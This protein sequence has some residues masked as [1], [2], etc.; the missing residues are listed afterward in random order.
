MKQIADISHHDHPINWDL[1]RPALD[2]VIFRASI[3]KDGKDKKYLQYTAEC[4]L[5]YG[6]YHYVKAGTAEEAREEAK[7]F[8][9]FA[10]SAIQR[11]LFYIADIEYEAQTEKTTEPVCIAF[12][13][14]LRKLG[15]KKIGLYINRKYKYAGKAIDMC[16]IVW[17]P[18]WGPND[19]NI[20]GD[21]A[22]PKHYNDIW[23]YTSEGHLPG[24]DEGVDLDLLNGDKPLEY[25][26]E[27][28]VPPKREEEPAYEKFTNMHFVDFCRKFVG[29]PYWYGTTI[30]ACTE[31]KLKSKAKQYPEHY[32]EDRMSRYKKDIAQ[33]KICADCVG[34]IK[35]YI[36][37]NAGEGVIESIGKEKPL[38]K[39]EYESRGMPDKSANSLFSYAKKQGLDWGDIDT[40]PE[41]PGLGLHK[42][43]HVGVYIGNGEAIEERGFNYG[44][45]KTKVKDRK[46]LHWF[47]IP[48]IIYQENQAVPST[49]VLGETIL[50]KGSTGAA[51][52]ELQTQ[53]NIL[54]KSD[55]EVDGIFG[56][57]TR[58][59]VM[60]FQAEFELPIT[61]VYDEPSHKA[62][63]AALSDS[64]QE[65]DRQQEE[66]I[67][68][69]QSEEVIIP[70]GPV[71]EELIIPERPA[72][73]TY[74]T[75]NSVNVRVGDGTSYEKIT[76]LGKNVS[77]NIVMGKDDKPVVS[78]NGWYA[79]YIMGR[80]GWLSGNYVKEGA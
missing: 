43:G 59:A 50:K 41:I 21:S 63:M 54:L 35:G 72:G 22:K 9:E 64:S 78:A 67:V 65:E 13:E 40:L 73:K 38:F 42:D 48:S 17:I 27:G 30:N 74:S 10:N 47:K 53:L 6:A 36:W 68:P 79:I 45:V 76:H 24:I 71:E 14:E 19:G 3:G 18:H 77:I 12:L 66:I 25:F 44:C 62:L 23:Q 1:M 28:W 8:V 32:A 46:W 55:L 2:L 39:R 60:Q 15:C 70:A 80:I 31:S 57:L 49:E 26:T 37:E 20:P 11:P 16:D 7:W 4:G 51:V 56:V 33:H 75:S 52:K 29:Q 69:E 58:E 61:G 34:L 5:P